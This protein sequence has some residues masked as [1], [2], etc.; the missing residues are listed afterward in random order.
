MAQTFLASGLRGGDGPRGETAF[1]KSRLG[2]AVRENRG[3][4]LKESAIVGRYEWILRVP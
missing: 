1:F 4:E 3:L 2:H